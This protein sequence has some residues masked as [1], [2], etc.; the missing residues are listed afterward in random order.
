MSYIYFE[1]EDMKVEVQE[2]GGYIFLHMSAEK[3][4]K[5]ILRTIREVVDR[6]VEDL[7]SEG[8]EWAF[9]TSEDEKSVK[10]WNIVKPCYTIKKFGPNE[11]YWIGAWNFEEI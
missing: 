1:D 10:F 5:K 6:L 4:N 8:H 11:E 9:A 3:W 7:K 2:E